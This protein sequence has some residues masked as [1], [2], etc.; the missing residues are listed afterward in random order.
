MNKTGLSTSLLFCFMLVSM[1]LTG[2]VSCVCSLLSI[3][4]IIIVWSTILMMIDTV[5]YDIVDLDMQLTSG[6]IIKFLAIIR[7]I[8]VLIIHLFR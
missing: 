5:S 1:I 2:T 7:L 8:F 6:C 4:V 3:M